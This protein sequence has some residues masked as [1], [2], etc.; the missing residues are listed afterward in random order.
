MDN[1]PSDVR[2]LIERTRRHDGPTARDKDRVSQKLGLAL[3]AAGSAASVLASK[4]AAAATTLAVTETASAGTTAVAGASMTLGTAIATVTNAATMS[5][6]AVAVT[7]TATPAVTVA[8]SVGAAASSAGAASA[9]ASGVGAGAV[10]A[11]VT[12]GALVGKAVVAPAAVVATKWGGGTLAAWLVG[13]G[14]V[15]ASVLSVPTVSKK[16]A[17]WVNVPSVAQP[18]SASALPTAGEL[19]RADSVRRVNGQLT[20]PS[21]GAAVAPTSSGHEAQGVARG[22]APSAPAVTAVASNAPAVTVVADVGA[23]VAVAPATAPM[24][25]QRGASPSPAKPRTASSES[26]DVASEVVLLSEAQRALSEGDANRSLSLLQQHAARF[27]TSTLATERSAARV[28]AY[29]QL[30]RI[31]EARAAARGFFRNGS[32]SPLLPKVQTSCVGA[33]SHDP[34]TNSARTGN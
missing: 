1:L 6:S 30:G 8:S 31:D 32:N 18:S 17:H 5:A 13:A 24:A 22:A 3:A 7:T 20:E 25:V 27:P 11:A 21:T 34:S 29:C 15:G 28:F 19:D 26:N 9:V 10:G 16:V 23:A 33:P 14:A 4:S 2:A 12:T